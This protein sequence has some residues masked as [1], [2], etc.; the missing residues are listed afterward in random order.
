MINQQIQPNRFLNG[1]LYATND[2]GM[3]QHAITC[4]MQIIALVDVNQKDQYPGC[5]C[6]TNL[7]P[8]P[9]VITDILDGN[10]LGG[11]QKYKSYLVDPKREQTV[12]CILAALYRKPQNFLLYVE[13]DPDK[14]FHIIETITG[15]FAEAF[16]IIIGWYGDVRFPA[17]SIANPAYDFIIADLLFVNGYIDMKE[18]ALMTPPD[19]VPSPRA[20]SIILRLINYG[21]NTMEDAVRIAMAILNDVRL[22]VQTGKINPILFVHPQLPSSSLEELH[23]RKVESDIL[24]A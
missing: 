15:F 3:L 24:N 8:P 13:Y 18:Y 20:C 9:D 14:E 16:G 1:R 4:G 23:K 7:L 22:E 11:V 5:I 19:A 12:V 6:L 21:V 17:A 10:V 2:P